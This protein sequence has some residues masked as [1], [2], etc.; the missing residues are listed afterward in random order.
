MEKTY[1]IVYKTTNLINGKIYIGVHSTNNL[2]DGYIG[3][4]I[5][6][7]GN[8]NKNTSNRSFHN[9][10]KK[11]GYNNFRR[12]ILYEFG[13]AELAYW[14]ESYLVDEDFVKRSDNYNIKG[15]GSSKF[16]V[17]KETRIKI[18]SYKKG[19]RLS[20]EHK[21]KIRES[22]SNKKLSEE[23]KKRISIARAG[24]IPWNKNKKHTEETRKKMSA[25]LLSDRS[26][27][28][29]SVKCINTGE[30]FNSIKDAS[31]KTLIDGGL[32]GMCAK[33]KRSFAGKNLDGIPLQWEFINKLK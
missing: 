1:N 23:H 17:S 13:S 31:I 26:N 33:G 22:C 10:I 14:W 8:V 24:I 30:I 16:Y 28:R 19:R 29:K 21:R 18:G 20:E 27:K 4:G 32:I 6:R 12:E 2:E 5:Y 3:N 7:Q 25:Y 9:A 11:Y 15:G